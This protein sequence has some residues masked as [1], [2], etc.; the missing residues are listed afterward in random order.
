MLWLDNILGIQET[1]NDSFS[2]AYD[3]R[4]F[5]DPNKLRQAI[6]AKTE[7]TKQEWLLDTVGI[8]KEVEKPNGYL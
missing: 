7:T 1:A 8:G 5:D 2:L 3:F 4:V 6:E